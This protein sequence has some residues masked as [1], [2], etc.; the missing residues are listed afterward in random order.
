MARR[1]PKWA[2]RVDAP[3]WARLSSWIVGAVVW[4][5]IVYRFIVQDLPEMSVLGQPGSELTLDGPT[6]QATR[7]ELLLDGLFFVVVAT[8]VAA[9]AMYL[10]R[11][12]G[13]GVAWLRLRF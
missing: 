5:G 6:T 10:V 13:R 12:I 4:L 8:A 7:N 9:F 3:R 11:L 1:R 2:K